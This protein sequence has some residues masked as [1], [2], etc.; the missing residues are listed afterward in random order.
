MDGHEGTSQPCGIVPGPAT[1]PEPA[2][3]AIERG[4]A[5]LLRAH[6]YASVSELPLPDGRRADVVGLAADGRIII[7]EI[8]SCLADYQSDG[9]WPEYRAWCDALYFAVDAG[10][11]RDVLPP[12]TG[13]ILADRFGGIFERA[14]PAHPLV[15]ARRKSMTL[16]FARAAA[17]RLHAMRDPECLA[18]LP[19]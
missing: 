8:K 19:A 18:I 14:A 7:V 11:P 16:R 12:D 13:L 6:D 10:F 5:R 15:A 4:V 3:R 1:P 9:K 2:A 17:A